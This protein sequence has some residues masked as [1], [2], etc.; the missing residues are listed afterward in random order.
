VLDVDVT[1]TELEYFDEVVAGFDVASDGQLQMSSI[2]HQV[3]LTHTTKSE[4][5]QLNASILESLIISHACFPFSSPVLL[6]KDA[7]CRAILL[8]T[9][10]CESNFKQATQTAGRQTMRKRSEQKRLEFI[11]SALACPPTGTPTHDDI[12]DVISR[13][14]YPWL[15]APKGIVRRRPVT[16]FST[17]AQRL[18]PSKDKTLPDPLPGSILKLLESL[19]AA[20]PPRWNKVVSGLDF[21]ESG[22][23]SARQFVQWATKVWISIAYHH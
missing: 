22:E 15:V 21:E 7:F 14:Q 9:D 3:I 19:V 10:R 23:L 8:L 5:I 11:Y 2:M 16:D 13:V 20:F 18:E 1:P 4:V 6:T 12:L 17:L